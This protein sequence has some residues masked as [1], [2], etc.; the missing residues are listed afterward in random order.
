MKK[1]AACWFLLVPV[2]ALNAQ[3]NVGINIANPIEMLDVN[4]NANFRGLL[5]VNN[6]AGATGQ[7]LTSQG[8]AADPIW[9]NSAY[10]GGG[11]FWATI[12]NSVRTGTQTP[13]GRGGNWVLNNPGETTQEDT[14]DFAATFVQGSD[15][16]VSNQGTLNNYITINKTGLY[17]FEAVIRTFVTGDVDGLVMT[18]RA[19]MKLRLLKAGVVNTDLYMEETLMPLSAQPSTGFANKSY[20]YTI[21][22]GIDIN[23]ETGTTVAFYPGFNQLR[24]TEAIPLIAMGLTSGGYIS[25][26]F[27][28]N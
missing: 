26:Q 20:N 5:K 16:T 23:L 22:F 9:A 17:H 21:K 18:P 3:S 1:V 7:V 27:M 11:R 14:V 8:A 13:T 10:T 28:A 25:G 6:N 4:G 15:I 2:L 12:A 24:M 19:T